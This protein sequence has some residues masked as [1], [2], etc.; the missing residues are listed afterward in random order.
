M[1]V[2]IY[3]FLNGIIETIDDAI[4]FIYRIKAVEHN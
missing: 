3:N 2:Q 4:V 1:A